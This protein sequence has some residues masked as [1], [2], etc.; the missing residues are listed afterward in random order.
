MEDINDKLSYG[1]LYEDPEIFKGQVTNVE[2]NFPTHE[3]MVGK[4]EKEEKK[5]DTTPTTGGENGKDPKQGEGKGP[6]E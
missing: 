5:P 4:E 3:S 2:D 6:G 1:N